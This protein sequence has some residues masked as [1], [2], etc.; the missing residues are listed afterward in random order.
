M[1]NNTNLS[2]IRYRIPAQIYIYYEHIDC[3][4]S[5]NFVQRYEYFEKHHENKNNGYQGE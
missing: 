4:S 3:L 1:V 2:G 5:P